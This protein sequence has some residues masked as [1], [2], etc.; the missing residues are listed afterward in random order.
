MPELRDEIV[1][2][3]SENDGVFTGRALQ[4]MKKLDSFLKETLRTNPATM[5]EL[6]DAEDENKPPLLTSYQLLSSAR[7]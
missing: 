5:G 7:Y 6:S 2:A 4:S 3:L 1:Q